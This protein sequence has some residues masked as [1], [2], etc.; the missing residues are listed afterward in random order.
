[1][2]SNIKSGVS[3]FGVSGSYKSDVFWTMLTEPEIDGSSILFGSNSRENT[4]EAINL[5]NYNILYVEGSWIIGNSYEIERYYNFLYSPSLGF[6][7]ILRANPSIESVRIT[8]CTPITNRLLLSVSDNFF[9][10]GDQDNIILM[11]VRVFCTPK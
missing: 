8:E 3:I 9:Q 1:M 11:A 10:T 5:D 4:G 6:N 2:A 7:T